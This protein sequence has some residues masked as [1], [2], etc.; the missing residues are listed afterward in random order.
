MNHG[1]KAW[2][3]SRGKSQEVT[4]QPYTGSKGKNKKQGEIVNPQSPLPNS[5]A[6]KFH[7]QTVPPTGEQVFK[8]MGL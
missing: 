1:E 2:L 8:D 6:P 7:S 4:S 5:Q 3:G